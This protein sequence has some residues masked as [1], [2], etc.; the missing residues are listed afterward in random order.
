MVPAARA[1]QHPETD[2][3]S[4]RC[5]AMTAMIAMPRDDGDDRDAAR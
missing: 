3:S 4:R 1:R 2:G 5:R